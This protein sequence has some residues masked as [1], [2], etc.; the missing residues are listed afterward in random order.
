MKIDG[1]KKVDYKTLQAELSKA[2]K[3]DELPAL[4]IAAKVNVNSVQTVWNAFN[5]HRQTVSDAVLSGV[6][7]V[8][9]I[10]SAIIWHKGER[11]YYIRQNGKA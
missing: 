7:E 8:L 1:F 5:I 6:A 4:Q 10:E 11:N 3:P 9:G 2:H